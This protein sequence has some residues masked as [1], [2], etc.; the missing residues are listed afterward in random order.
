M[1]EHWESD[2]NSEAEKSFVILMTGIKISNFYSSSLK[3]HNEK[4]VL[5]NSDICEL[6]WSFGQ[7]FLPARYK[8]SSLV[9]KSMSCTDG[10]T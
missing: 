8:H 9:V 7:V 6:D 5:G 10:L 3:S 4:S 2:F 1:R